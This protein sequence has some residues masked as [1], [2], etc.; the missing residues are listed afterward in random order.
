MV[1]V[2]SVPLFLIDKW[3]IEEGL[4]YFNPDHQ[5]ALL[6]RYNSNEYS[7]LRTAPGRL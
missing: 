1:K 5:P 6:A 2:A 4:D 7:K 3:R